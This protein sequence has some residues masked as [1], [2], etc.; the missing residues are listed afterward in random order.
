MTLFAYRRRCKRHGVSKDCNA[1]PASFAA[2]EKVAEFFD[3]QSGLSKD[4]AQCPLRNFL[5][6]GNGQASVRLGLLSENYVASSLPV[7]RIS[8]FLQSLDHIPA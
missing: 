8:D 1:G 5:V 7:E 2:S 4:C 6:I 3:R